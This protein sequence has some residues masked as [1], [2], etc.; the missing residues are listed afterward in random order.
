[1]GILFDKNAHFWIYVMKKRTLVANIL[2][3]LLFLIAMNTIQTYVLHITKR[4]GDLDFYRLPTHTFG[5]I[6]CS[7][8]LLS[9][10][11]AWRVTSNIKLKRVSKIAVG[12]TFAIV[13]FAAIQS[14]YYVAQ[15]QLIYNLPTSVNMLVGNFIFT[16]VIYHLYISA[17][18]LA[19]LSFKE[20]AKFSTNL[21][22]VEK[23]K[24]MLQ[25]KM[26]QKNLE[27]HFLFNNL[28]VLSGMIK[29]SPAEVDTFID[30][31]ADV[32]RYYLN[33]NNQELVALEKELEF[34]KKYISLM[35]KRFKNAYSFEI[36]IADHIGFILPCALQLAVEN[37]IKH[38]S[39]SNERPLHIVIC[40][41][42]DAIQISNDFRP[43]DFTQGSQLGNR[44]LQKSYELN[45]SKTVTFE[46]TEN[47]YTVTIPLIK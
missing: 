19:Y 14:V 28:S 42:K 1:M 7:I 9:T 35:Q 37:A 30:N 33:H 22:N 38:N 47:K 31:F 36:L 17:L 27:P 21:F 45:F 24:E 34:L 32:Y 16:S 20:S 10:V 23:E 44:F 39:G 26:L 43:V 29:K 18:T 11:I 6:S 25:F 4:F 5:I 12:F 15:R 13:I 40:R 3:V 41:N 8:S 2:F 46:Q